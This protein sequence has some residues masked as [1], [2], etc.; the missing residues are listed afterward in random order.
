MT[1]PSAP[2]ISELRKRKDRVKSGQIT[3]PLRLYH[4]EAHR[5]T[6]SEFTGDMG[7]DEVQENKHKRFVPLLGPETRPKQI[8]APQKPADY[9]DK[10]GC[11]WCPYCALRTRFRYDGYLGVRRCERCGISDND[12]YVKRANGLWSAQAR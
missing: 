4:K 9:T 12:F 5:G 8:V 10:R 1:R 3:L 2:D 6:S 11:L 7:G